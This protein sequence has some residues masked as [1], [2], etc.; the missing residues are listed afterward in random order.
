MISIFPRHNFVLKIDNFDE[1]SLYHR[2]IHFQFYNTM[3]IFDISNTSLSSSIIA[4]IEHLYG[5]LQ[6][7]MVIRNHAY[8]FLKS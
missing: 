5:V 4:K 1:K 6:S 2:N 3:D 8:L 7:S